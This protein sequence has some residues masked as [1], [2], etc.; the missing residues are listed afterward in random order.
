MHVHGSNIWPEHTMPKQNIERLNNKS[1]FFGRFKCSNRKTK[2]NKSDE[3]VCQ[4]KLYPNSFYCFTL[5]S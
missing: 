4:C 1:W 5:S 2:V 3:K